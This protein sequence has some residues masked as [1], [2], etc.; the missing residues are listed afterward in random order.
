MT[1]IKEDRERQ[2]KLEELYAKDGRHEQGHPMRGLY[3]GL[4]QEYLRQCEGV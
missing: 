4:W 1:T 3:T 2:A